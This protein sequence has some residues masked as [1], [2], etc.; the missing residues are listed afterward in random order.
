M[1]QAE[2]CANMEAQTEPDNGGIPRPTLGLIQESI[3]TALDTLRASW[4]AFEGELAG[5]VTKL[6][7]ASDAESLTVIKVWYGAACRE[8]QDVA[9]HVAEI[10]HLPVETAKRQIG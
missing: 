5:V 7:S 2:S 3:Q 6:E 1:F 10:D 9:E 8:W 4:V